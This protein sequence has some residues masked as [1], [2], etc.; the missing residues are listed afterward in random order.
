M[1]DP[2][3][4]SLAWISLSR[5]RKQLHTGDVTATVEA[6]LGLDDRLLR[7]IMQ[8]LKKVEA[9]YTGFSVSRMVLFGQKFKCSQV[10]ATLTETPFMTDTIHGQRQ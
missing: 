8:P 2:Q 3:E 5:N 4:L 10:R 7:K 6:D 1:Q 9:N